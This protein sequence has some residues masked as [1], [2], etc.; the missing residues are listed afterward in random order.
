MVANKHRVHIL[1]HL[2]SHFLRRKVEEFAPLVSESDWVG[3]TWYRQVVGPSFVRST[4]EGELGVFQGVF[5]P[6]IR[7]HFVIGSTY[8]SPTRQVTR[9]G[10]SG[11]RQDLGFAYEVLT[12]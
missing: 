1:R 7:Q 10:A 12:L 3:L 8:K 9:Q 2:V 11:T 4:T 5:Y 6:S